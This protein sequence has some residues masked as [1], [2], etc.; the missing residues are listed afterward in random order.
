MER[1]SIKHWHS[2]LAMRGPDVNMFDVAHQVIDAIYDDFESRTCENCIHSD[3]KFEEEYNDDVLRCNNM[4]SL[5]WGRPEGVS[6]IDT[7]NKFVR[8]VKNK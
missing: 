5:G 2:S 1:D 3:L 4:L 8:K 6:L 7:C